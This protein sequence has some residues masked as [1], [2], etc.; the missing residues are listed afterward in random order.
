MKEETTARVASEIRPHQL[1]IPALRPE[2]EVLQPED[3]AEEGH[4]AKIRKLSPTSHSTRDLISVNFEIDSFQLTHD[5]IVPHKECPSLRLLT[6]SHWFPKIRRL[7]LNCRHLDTA[8]DLISIVAV[9][10]THL[11]HFS[12]KLSGTEMCEAQVTKDV[13]HCLWHHLQDQIQEGNLHVWVH[14]EPDHWY[15]RITSEDPPDFELLPFELPD[16][17]IELAAEGE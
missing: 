5:S 3:H 17:G 4:Q 6:Q 15:A 14:N 2:P 1:R 13:V 7:I 9:K 12:V 16:L 10:L 11:K 8:I